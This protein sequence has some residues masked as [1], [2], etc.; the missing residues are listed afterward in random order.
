MQTEENVPDAGQREIMTPADFRAE[1]E[2]GRYGLTSAFA[3]GY[4]QALYDAGK[5]EMDGL[6]QYVGAAAGAEL[7]RNLANPCSCIADDLDMAAFE[8]S[9]E[10]VAVSDMLSALSEA[11]KHGDLAAFER[12]WLGGKQD[13]PAAAETAD[14]NRATALEQ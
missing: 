8:I 4:A 7:R 11:L 12:E 10:N 14:G 9:V 1:I 2:A 5:I 13:A 6:S 3:Q